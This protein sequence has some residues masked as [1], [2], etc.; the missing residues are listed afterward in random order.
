MRYIEGQSLAAR[1]A[2]SP[3]EPQEAATLVRAIAEAVEYAHQKGVIHRDLKP[4][5]VMLDAAGHPRIT[6]FG[7][8]RQVQG[9]SHLTGTGQ[10]LGTPSYMPPEQA[11]G[12]VD[13]IGPT[14][15]V[16]ALGAILYRLL[17][18][19]PPFQAAN[20]L[21]TLLQVLGQEPLALQQL[22]PGV[23]LDLETI[24]LKCLEK[25]PPRRYATAQELADELQRY[26]SG[27]PILA[28]PVSRAERGWRWCR[29]QPVVAAL[30]ATVVVAMLVGTVISSL[31]ALEA[32]QRAEGEAIQRHEAEEQTRTATEQRAIADRERDAANL[33]LC[34]SDM[35]LA[36]SAWE[37]GE[38]GT[39]GEL[40]DRH[41]PRSG[42]QD[43]RGWEWY[44]LQAKCSET[45]TLRGL[46]S[47][48]W[49]LS[50]SPDGQRLAASAG[51]VMSM[52]IWNVKTRR[53]MLAIPARWAS[54]S[55][56]G[57]RLV[58]S[59][60]TDLV[61]FL[62]VTRKLEPASARCVDIRPACTASRGA[63]MAGGLR[64]A[65]TTRRYVFRRRW[66]VQIHRSCEG[67][68]AE[69]AAWPGTRI[70]VR[71]RPQAPT[72]PSGFGIRTQ[73]ESHARRW[74]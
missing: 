46:G 47:A 19:R 62:S 45:F 72:R 70:R 4:E 15:D 3:M 73:D 33:S 54:F 34:F 40:L 32:R 13:D 51:W 11:A 22:N 65:A 30:S 71:S 27:Q 61:K 68:A 31:F 25:H 66:R 44:L 24:A 42:K 35:H 21:D 26:L 36:N 9:D 1:V 7:L 63:R 74:H 12:K 50:W 57:Q 53:E 2:R 8:A 49:Q 6:D 43:L 69:S 59:G 23:P 55:P 38:I 17:T 39:L 52:K 29:R 10:I 28:R 20:P 64:Q 60:E 37:L 67:T 48:V 14:S 16:Y 56:D 58:T 41:R 18:G 5:N